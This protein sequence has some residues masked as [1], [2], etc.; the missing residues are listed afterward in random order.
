MNRNSVTRAFTLIELLVVMAIISILASM[1]LPSLGRAKEKAFAI[2]CVNNLKQLGLA[3]QMYGDDNG[4]RL[5]VAYG[6]TAW[7]NTNPE[8][9][10]RPL[11][12]YY[13]TTNILTCPSLSRKYNQSPFNYFIGARAAFIEAGFRP[14]GVSLRG[15]RFPT[16]YILSGDSN[17]P[18]EA[19]NADQV[20]YTQDTLFDDRYSPPPVHNE[21]LNV[22]F[23][24][25]H[26]KSYRRFNRGEMTYS[27]HLPSVEY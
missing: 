1:L 13:V 22:L 2:S 9:W 27:Y 15:M 16:Q 19:W 4:E 8:P 25:F 24:D 6:R 12:T 26:V 3:M 21:R 17:Y 7:T 5:P 14:A 10:T 20:N 18:S 11:L 23:G